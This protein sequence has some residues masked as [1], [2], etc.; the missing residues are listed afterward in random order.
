MKLQEKKILASRIALISGIFSAVIS[1]V[2]L[3]NYGQLQR[4]E[5]IDNEVLTSMVEQL[6]EDPRNDKLKEEIRRLDLMVR[7]AYFTKQWQ[8]RSGAFMLIGGVVILV[9]ALRYHRSYESRIQVPAPEDRQMRKEL[10][11]TQKWI[12]ISVFFIFGLALVAAYLSDDQLSEAYALTMPEENESEPEVR[13]ISIRTREE[14]Q[15]QSR[16]TAITEEGENGAQEGQDAIQPA[17]DPS[18]EVEGIF[19]ETENFEKVIP[20]TASLRYVDQYPA[21]RGPF[22]LG[23]SNH[24]NLPVDWDGATGKNVLWKSRIP[25]HGYNSPVIWGDRIFLS[26]ASTSEQLIYCFDRNDGSIIWQHAVNDVGRTEN[27]VP[28][29]SEDTGFAAS[30][31]AADGTYVCA[32]FATGDVVC[33]DMSGNRKWARNL[34]MPDNHYGHSS[35]LLTYQDL[36]LVQFDTNA[37]GKVLGLDLSSGEQKWSTTRSSKI[38]WASPILANM[39]DHMELILASSPLVAAYNPDSGEEIWGLECLMG[40]VGPSPAFDDGIVFATNEYAAL[41]AIRPGS[42]AEILWESND[43]LPEV[44]SPVADQGMLFLG[45]SY[46]VIACYDASN[47]EILWEYECDDGIY[48]SPV[49]A[50]NKV[51]FLD[52]SGKMHIFSVKRTMNLI[53]EPELGERSVSTPAFS[54]GRIYLKSDDYLYCIGK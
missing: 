11:L 25:L 29:V 34:G 33:L 28:R 38:S 19:E 31:V 40:E 1:V 46:G 2:M 20:T 51:Y 26:G 21:F 41:V 16:E 54:D 50:E 47:G 14:I 18:P 12:L 48:A 52:M 10:M 22:S 4:S 3:L 17:E 36:L 8:V 39:G 27:K 53:G 32:I 5:P 15:E 43:Y 35:S 9:I 42:P 30:T 45:T 23:V 7:K 24:K 6:K 37:E 49:I 13:E 44:A